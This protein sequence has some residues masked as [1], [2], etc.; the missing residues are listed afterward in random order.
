MTP[1]AYDGCEHILEGRGVRAINGTNRQ[2]CVHPVDVVRIDRTLCDEPVEL[3]CA[4][5]AN[6][7]NPHAERSLAGYDRISRVP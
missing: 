2:H 6:L 5:P 3:T 1:M 7:S 4:T